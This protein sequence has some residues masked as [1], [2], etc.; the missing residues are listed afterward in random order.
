MKKIRI[1]RR[2]RSRSF[3]EKFA[4]DA[5][6]FG[7]GEKHTPTDYGSLPLLLLCLLGATVLTVAVL[8]LG[9]IP[10]VRSTVADEGV[11][12]TSTAVLAHAGIEEGDEMLGFDSFAVAKKLK[13]SL[14]LM[15]KVKV[16][17]H[18]DGSVTVRFTEV[19]NLFYTCHNQNYYIINA[20]TH[21]VLCVS[22]ET[23]EARRVGAIYLGIPE[24]TRVRVGEPLT[25][26][27]LPYAPETDSSEVFDYELETD[28]PE[29]ENAYVFE[30]VESLMASSLGENVVGMELG[31]RYD[32]YFVLKGSIR[33]RVGSMEELDRKL[34]LVARVLQDK[35]ESGGIP[36]GMSSL[37]DV[38]DPARVIHRASPDIEM[39][40]WAGGGVG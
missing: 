22:G 16:R 38:S 26:I 29:V 28:E 3:A 13:Q 17:K 23:N 1:P 25:F 19:Q 30:F 8:L 24:S 21:D 18:L 20:D 27:N 39:P 31:D 34:T 11:Y 32:M 33:V 15:D 9:K 4:R 37:I 12:Y 35:S 14:P 40:F 6:P 36:E 5:R 7:S 2:G 10:K